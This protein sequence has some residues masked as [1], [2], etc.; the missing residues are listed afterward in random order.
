MDN[1]NNDLIELISKMYGEMQKG[2]K[3]VNNRI[4]SLEIEVKRNSIGIE[5]LEALE[6][7]TNII[8]EVLDNH[9]K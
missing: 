6:K 7:K 4:D 9:I 3:G 5:A 8:A 2:F 1:E